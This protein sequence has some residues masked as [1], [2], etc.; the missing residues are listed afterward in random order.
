MAENTEHKILS[1]T[2][3]SNGKAHHAWR[4]SEETLARL[5]SEGKIE[6]PNGVCT[7]GSAEF[8]DTF[9]HRKVKCMNVTADRCEL[10]ETSDV[11]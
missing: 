6:S 3:E 4:A 1:F 7:C 9:T 2:Y 10:F 11:C 5:H 8:C